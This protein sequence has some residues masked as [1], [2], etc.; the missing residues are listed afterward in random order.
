MWRIRRLALLPVL[1]LLITAMA[2]ISMPLANAG[3]SPDP[4]RNV[5]AT[6]HDGQ[7]RYAECLARRPRRHQPPV[8]AGIESAALQVTAGAAAARVTTSITVASPATAT[9]T[10]PSG[11]GITAVNVDDATVGATTPVTVSG[12]DGVGIFVGGGDGTMNFGDTSVTGYIG[13]AVEV[14]SRT[15]GT[16]TFRGPITGNLADD[17]HAGVF[18]DANPDSTVAFT[19]KL[20]LTYFQAGGTYPVDEGGEVTATGA[21]STI[22]GEL[23]VQNTT[24]GAAGLR[25]QSISNVADNYNIYTTGIDLENTGSVGGSLRVTG[26][27]TPG[28]GGTID[29]MVGDADGE[30]NIVL[31]NTFAPSFTDMVIKDLSGGI[32]GD[33]VNGLTLADCTLT[34]APWTSTRPPPAIPAACSVPCRSPTP[35]SQTPPAPRPS[36]T[37]ARRST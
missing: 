9:L 31:N 7:L 34:D 27:G 30:G 23:A 32:D 16:V 15:G 18:L 3:T 33:Q 14:E 8:L 5:C 4:G 13:A 6:D 28:S 1:A 35:P 19:G 26:T 20:T 36:A 25:F 21:G 37:P 22:N 29:G 17:L 12:A 24:I 2:A 11:N 10:G